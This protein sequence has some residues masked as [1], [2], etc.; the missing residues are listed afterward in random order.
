MALKSYASSVADGSVVEEPS[1]R[2]VNITWI[3]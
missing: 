1:K 2:T 3:T